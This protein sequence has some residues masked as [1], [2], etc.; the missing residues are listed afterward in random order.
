MVNCRAHKNPTDRAGVTNTDD[1][2]QM[3]WLEV[4]DDAAAGSG[5]LRFRCCSEDDGMK[6][7]YGPTYQEAWAAVVGLILFTALVVTIV[8]RVEP[9]SPAQPPIEP[10]TVPW[11]RY[12]PRFPDPDKWLLPTPTLDSVPPARWPITRKVERSISTNRV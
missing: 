8:D 3:T 9:S 11:E 4:P 5:P 7:P 10:T 6:E 1:H 12:I 2:V